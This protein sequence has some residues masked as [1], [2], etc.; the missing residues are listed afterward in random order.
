MNN[1][2][3][4][5]DEVRNLVSEALEGTALPA[6]AP[7]IYL[8][9]NLF[10]K[11]GI[12]VSEAARDDRELGEALG[13]LASRL[14]DALGAHGHLPEKTVLFVD[15]ALLETLS[16]TAQLIRPGVYWADRLVVGQEWWTVAGPSCEP[17]PA[18]Y[19]LYSVKGGVGRS[20]TAA[21]LAWHLARR[22]EDV[23]VIDLDLESPGLASA[24]LEPRAQPEFGVTDWF[25]EELVGQGDHVVS[26]MTGKPSWAHDLPGRVLVAPAHGEE[27]GEYLAKLGRAYMDTAAD[28]W[29]R[30]LKR[31]VAN[32]EAEF[33]PTVVLIESRSGLHD[34]AA[35]T[36]TD[37]DAEVMLFAVDSDSHWTD[38]G[39]LFDHWADANVASRIRERLSIVSALTPE[40]YAER[41][42]ERFRDSAR[43]LLRDRLQDE[44]ADLAEIDDGVSADLSSEEGQ[45]DPLV[46]HWTRG[47]ATGI[48]L[49]RMERTTVN[50]A[51]TEFLRRFDLLYRSPAPVA[52]A[53]GAETMR[54]AVSELPGP[55]SYGEPPSPM[56]VYIPPSHRKAMHPDTPLVTGMRGSGKT[57]WWS[58]LQSP[59]VR[60][61]LARDVPGFPLNEDSVVE[62]GFGVPNAPADYPTREEL[63]GLVADKVEPRIIWQT[64]HVCAVAATGHPIRRSDV[65][66]ER[67]RY[68][69]D[70]PSVVPRLLQDIDADLNA[71]GV[72]SVVL[73]DALDRAAS[74]WR[75]ASLLIRGLLEHALDMRPY[76]RLRAKVFLRTDQVDQSRVRDFPDASKVLSSAVDLSWPRRD[77]Y[78]LLWHSLANGPQGGLVR[79]LLQ[80]EGDWPSLD[81]DSALRFEVP[82][83]L[84]GD[85]DAQRDKFHE[86]AG[87]WMGTDR[88]RGYPYTWIPNH[89]ADARGKVGPRSFLAAL[90]AAASDTHECYPDHGYALHYRSIMR[91]VRDASETRVQE[92]Q[93]DHPWVH[94]LMEPLAGQV[95]PC[96]FQ[97]VERL[98]HDR[99]VLARL[100][101]AG[102]G[103]EWRL[104]PRQRR[105]HDGLRQVLE[106]L[107]IFRRLRDGRVDVPDV[108]R[109][110]YGLRRKGGVRPAR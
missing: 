52:G 65:W 89:L 39:I 64:V 37:L 82:Y 25:V 68:V 54:L 10:G 85:E 27:P 13:C 14:A 99:A 23:L 41:Y 35:A 103:G 47:F 81:G 84:A 7:P 108:F 88:R 76:R 18:R 49:R 50:Q 1:T 87:P 51:Y 74:E 78:G 102:P 67:V 70:N 17:H 91:G 55:A 20:T 32:L 107:G 92:L 22:A 28:P 80:Q 29:T 97:H 75:I 77:L 94:L 63:G 31:L 45:H 21:V 40:T 57:F 90:R 16:D 98:W 100:D 34:I 110:G 12:S 56:A 3:V 11:V 38:Y 101:E 42:V 36:V 26:R 60:R 73:F 24:M 46:I 58:A 66:S 33:S 109:I 104:P 30:R 83:S 69:L 19:V 9:C 106:S 79:P 86:F 6:G 93:E 43:V 15:P 71:R 4:P 2:F 62:R 59:E 72:Y 53:T 8:V 95:V 105:D 96:G 44:N 5:F 48:S 61:F